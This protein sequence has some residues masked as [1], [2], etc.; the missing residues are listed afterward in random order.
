MPTS[1]L[2]SRTVLTMKSGLVVSV[3]APRLLWR[4]E[5]TGMEVGGT[6]RRASFR[7]CARPV[8]PISRSHLTDPRGVVGAQECKLRF[9]HQL[10]ELDEGA[11]Q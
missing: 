1:A 10:A 8:R 7:Y 5:D 4:L 3:T 11:L 9:S 6:L 2:S